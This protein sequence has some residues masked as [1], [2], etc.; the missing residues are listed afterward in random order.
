M[1]DLCYDTPMTET[2]GEYAERMMQG[3]LQCFS[4]DLRWGARYGGEP[5]SRSLALRLF[6]AIKDR[7]VYKKL[8]GEP[9]N[10]MANGKEIREAVTGETHSYASYWLQRPEVR[11]A[12]KQLE[13]TGVIIKKM[14]NSGP[15]GYGD[16]EEYW[17]STQG[18]VLIQ[19]GK[20]NDKIKLGLENMML[21]RLVGNG[22]Y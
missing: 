4:M 8:A 10:V 17:L 11:A 14:R 12:F 9:D 22:A 18:S 3:R 5:R 7:C 21:D 1:F 6:M 13:D 16:D 2:C 15:Y 19:I 20:T